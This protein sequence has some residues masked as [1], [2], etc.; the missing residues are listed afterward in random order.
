M[1]RLS[2]FIFLMGFVGIMSCAG[3]PKPRTYS[4]K[5]WDALKD[6]TSAFR[7]CYWQVLYDETAAPEKS[8]M[9]GEVVVAFTIGKDGKATEAKIKSTTLHQPKVESCLLHE[10]LAADFPLHPQREPAQV[11]FPFTFKAE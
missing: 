1:R 9:S 2:H 5:V 7:T 3:T 11:T 6:Q 4:E 10:V 8:K